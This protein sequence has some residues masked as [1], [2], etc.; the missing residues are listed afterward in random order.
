MKLRYLHRNPVSVDW[1]QNRQSGS[2]A[3]FGIMSCEKSESW[4]SNPNGQQEIGKHKHTPDRRESFSTQVSAQNRGAN[5][6]HQAVKL[7]TTRDEDSVKPCAC[8][9]HEVSYFARNR[10]NSFRSTGRKVYQQLG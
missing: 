3:A 2:G 1:S 7:G 5:L 6:R 4:R 9:N 10:L 8:A